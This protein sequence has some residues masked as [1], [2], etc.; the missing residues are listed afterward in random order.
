MY[1]S[2]DPRSRLWRVNLK[3][4]FETKHVQ[5]NNAHDKNNQKD[6]INYLHA[7]CF[8]PVKSTWITAIKNG[9]FTSWPGLIEHAVEK[10]LSKSTSTTKGHLNQQRQNARTTK[11]KDP[12]VIMKEPDL[13]QGIKTQ[14][15]YA[16]TI[17]AGQIYTDQTGRFPV[18]SSK[19][20]KYIMILYDYDSNAILAQPIKDRTAHELLRAFQVMEQEVI[21]R[22]LKPKLMKLDN[23]AS[24]LLK[25]YL[26][27]QNITFQLV[28]PYSHRRNA[29]EMAIRS[30]KDHLIAGLCSTVTA[31]LMHLWDMLLPQA[32]ITLNMSR[33]SR[34]N[35]KLSSSTHIDGIY[36]FKRAPMAPPGTRIIAH[37][38]PSRRIT[39]APHGQYGW[40]IG[41]ALEHYRCYT[42]YINKTRGERLV[43][44]VYFFLENFKLPFPSTQELDTKAATELTHALLRPQ[45]AGPFCKFSDEQTLALKRLA[46][47]F[48]GATRQKS[49]VVIPPA[50]TVGNDAPPGVQI[51][52]SPPRVQKR[53]HNRGW[54]SKPHHHT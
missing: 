19:G 13:D 2:R 22:G 21:A 17:D 15:I 41:P 44:T 4:R 37:E 3:Q 12:K 18:V 46:D 48:E 14:Y 6:L 20:N 7:A 32:V 25:M 9:Y 50:E 49:R 52:V 10:H 54:H 34:I 30:F 43:E 33:T 45:P 5:C 47:I 29:A 40:Y 31:F 16:A 8:S 35:P 38:T 1:G 26:H 24:K 11:V 27:Q 23:E 42:V 36:D 28:P 39:W 53:Q 51:T